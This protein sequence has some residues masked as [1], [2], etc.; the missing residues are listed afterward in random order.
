MHF[1]TKLVRTNL[2]K[3]KSKEALP[4]T[5]SRVS[6]ILAQKSRLSKSAFFVHLKIKELLKNLEQK[7]LKKFFSKIAKKYFQVK[8]M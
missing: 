3:M 6:A 5:R 1:S 7:I 4:P 2:Q 8:F